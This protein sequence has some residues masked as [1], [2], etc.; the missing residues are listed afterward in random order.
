MRKQGI[1]RRRLAIGLASGVA[2]TATL[3]LQAR[4]VGGLANAQDAAPAPAPR[5]WSELADLTQQ[6][7][8]LGLSVPRMALSA[9]AAEETYS[10]TLPAVIDFMDSVE[11]SASDTRDVTSGEVD[12]IL[13]RAS[14]LLRKMRE[15]EKYREVSE[16]ESLRAAPV[17]R[18]KFENVADGYRELFASCDIRGSKRNQVAWYL[19]KVLDPK[20][21]KAYEQV[22]EETCVPWYFVAI[23]HG[24]EGGFDMRSH[25]H[26][27]DSL[28]RR[29]VHV[30]RNRPKNW[31]PPTDWVSSAVDALKYDKLVEKADW[32]LAK[33]MYRWESYNGWRSRLLH[34]INTPYLWSFSNHYTKGKYIAD[35]VWSGSAVSKQCGAAVMLK[36]LVEKGEISVPA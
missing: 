16:E 13:E 4:L 12:T 19:S 15:S 26:N 23:T 2:V 7:Q 10:E 6:A 3:P 30:P 18:P 21:R 24:M 17:S 11:G 31:N 20:R 29:T 25:L 9:S 8:E 32:D 34:G 14:A 28:R 1:D 22:Y 35:G 36:A 33:L 27:G 5:V